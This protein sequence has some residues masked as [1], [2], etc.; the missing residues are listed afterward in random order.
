M[1]Q[2]LSLTSSEVDSEHDCTNDCTNIVHDSQYICACNLACNMTLNA[3][4]G[5]EIYP[6]PQIRSD[7]SWRAGTHP[8][9]IVR[10]REFFFPP[11][12][13]RPEESC[14]LRPIVTHRLLMNKISTTQWV[15]HNAFES[16][17]CHDSDGT[18]WM[19]SCGQG[20][21]VLALTALLSSL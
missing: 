8:N 12:S 10:A 18:F 1:Y 16:C 15:P 13:L 6:A 21:P 7:H 17:S 9:R 4:Q 3:T 11:R 5:H 19:N 2:N 20:A 14:P